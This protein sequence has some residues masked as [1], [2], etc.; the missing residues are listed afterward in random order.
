MILEMLVVIM[1][2]YAG[3]QPGVNSWL[4]DLG[5][6]SNLEGL[7]TNLIAYLPCTPKFEENIKM[8]MKWSRVSMKMFSGIDPL[9]NETSH[10]ELDTEPF[11]LDVC[12]HVT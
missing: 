5:I 4:W 9:Q 11:N 6:F 10:E 3:G 12:P 7:R 1:E 8:L 2:I